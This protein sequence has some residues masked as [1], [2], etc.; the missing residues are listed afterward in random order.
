MARVLVTG[1][2]GFIGSHLTD[3]LLA[4]GDSVYGIDEFNDYYDPA[5]KRRNIASALEHDGFTLYEG[6]IRNGDWLKGI[7]AEVKPD[8][9][10]HLAARAGVR[11]SLEDPVLY[12]EVNIVGTQHLFDACVAHPPS[13]LVCASTSSV[14]GGI[15]E[16]P[17]HEEMNIDRPISPYAA[18]KRMTELMGHVYHHIHGL[19]FTFLRFFTVYGPRQRPDMAIHKFALRMKAGESIPMFGDG[20]TARD[21]TYIDDI[22]QGVERAVD[23]PFD[24]EIFNLGEQ[25][26][27]PL[28]QLI[29]MIGAAIGAEP[30]IE[31]MPMQPGDVIL[32]HADISKAREMLGYDPQ[33]HVDAGLEAFAA[34]FHETYR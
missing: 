14:Y 27:W 1:A 9:V 18:S 10:V 33:T 32:T 12:H 28:K 15:T 11:A 4:R 20:T 26:T 19:R 23:T 6:D 29:E 25:R 17:F 22:I 34:W 24:F 30:K 2:A 8:V 5:I 16:S 3:R 21:Y 31:Q 13:H 7:V